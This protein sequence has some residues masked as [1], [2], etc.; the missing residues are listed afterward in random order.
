[1]GSLRKEKCHTNK[2]PD[3]GWSE[4]ICQMAQKMFFKDFL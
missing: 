4:P 1:M 3:L 2:W